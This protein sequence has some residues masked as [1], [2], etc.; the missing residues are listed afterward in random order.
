MA[1][2]CVCVC[3]CVCVQYDVNAWEV[4][5]RHKTD[6]RMLATIARSYAGALRHTYVYCVY[7]RA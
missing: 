2:V 7:C 6:G 3:V 1:R 5:Q 4:S